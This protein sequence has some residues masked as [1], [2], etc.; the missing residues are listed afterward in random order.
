MVKDYL[1]NRNMRTKVGSYEY[2]RRNLLWCFPRSNFRTTSVQHFLCNHLLSLEIS[3]LPV[4]EMT[5]PPYVDGNN[6]EVLFE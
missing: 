4:T 3:G 5:F 2:L 1:Q 6:T